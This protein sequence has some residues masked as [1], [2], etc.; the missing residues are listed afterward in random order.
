MGSS[1]L[2]R[3]VPAIYGGSPSIRAPGGTP[4]KWCFFIPEGIPVQVRLRRPA[5][6]IWSAPTRC[7]FLGGELRNSM[8]QN[9]LW[10]Y[11]FSVPMYLNC[12]AKHHNNRIRE[13]IRSKMY[14]K[15]NKVSVRLR[16]ILVWGKVKEYIYFGE[17]N[18]A[19]LLMNRTYCTYVCT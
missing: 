13:A 1:P 15:Y 7:A 9:L 16:Y 11:I 12:S 17:N 5:V 10:E 3:N 4:V 6:E 18:N 19:K 14:S 2:A 8:H